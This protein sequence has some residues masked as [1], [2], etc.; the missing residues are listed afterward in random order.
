VLDIGS[1][2]GILS[3]AAHLLGARKVFGCDIHEDA[4]AASQAQLRSH[5]FQGSADAIRGQIADVVVANIS[6]KT[7]DALGWEL[8]RISKPNGLLIL[9][10]FIRE[11]P[12]KGFSPERI[13]DR[14]DWLCWLCRPQAIPRSGDRQVSHTHSLEWW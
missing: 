12:P 5:L 13:T 6:A 8:N 4:I 3:Q 10:G 11:N 1:G 2:S 9:T 14:G 7:I